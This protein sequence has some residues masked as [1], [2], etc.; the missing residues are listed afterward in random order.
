MRLKQVYR[1][2]RF[3]IFFVL[4]LWAVLLVSYIIPVNNLGIR[5]RSI[6]G[7]PG[8]FI[9]PFLHKGFSHLIANSMSILLLGVFLT[10]LEADRTPGIMVALAL[11]SGAGTWI[12]GRG[13]AVH[14]GA[15]GIIFG[16]LGYLF[17]AGFFYRNIKTIIVSLLIFL[18]YRGT[19]WGVLPAGKFISWE[20]H[21]SGFISGIILAWFYSKKVKKRGR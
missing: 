6:F 14:I 20:S 16:M 21:L 7:I 4:V 15:S 13:G 3:L 1:N 8:I 19:V 18:L 9:S 17:S 10:G 11:L 5:P 12:I 2:Y